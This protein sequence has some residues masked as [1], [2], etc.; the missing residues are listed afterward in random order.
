[1][2]SPG[3]VRL[4]CPSARTRLQWEAMWTQGWAKGV[5]RCS[6]QRVVVAKVFRPGAVVARVVGGDG[7]GKT[8]IWI[9][10]EK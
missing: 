6:D 4:G 9:F 1:M 8:T 2:S 10:L 7:V 3:M 5:E